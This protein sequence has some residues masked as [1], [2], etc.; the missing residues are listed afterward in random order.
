MAQVMCFS[1]VVVGYQSGIR[2]RDGLKT[3]QRIL[4]KGCPIRKK[5]F[6]ILPISRV[7]MFVMMRK[8]D[9]QSPKYSFFEIRPRNR[10]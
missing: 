5:N 1:V 7:K 4:D 6:E 9:S 3:I 8:L 10:V 2:G